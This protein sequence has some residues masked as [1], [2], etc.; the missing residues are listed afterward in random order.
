MLLNAW[1]GI[2]SNGEEC[3][4]GRVDISLLIYLFTFSLTSVSI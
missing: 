1:I 2:G 3:L 4:V